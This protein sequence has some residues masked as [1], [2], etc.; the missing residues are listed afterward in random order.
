MNLLALWVMRK[1]EYMDLSLFPLSNKHPLGGS[2]DRKAKKSVEPLLLDHLQLL[3]HLPVSLLGVP[4]LL[5]NPLFLKATPL[6]QCSF[7][8]LVFPLLFLTL[9]EHSW[10][11]LRFILIYC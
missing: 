1:R 9:L 2:A 7:P 3:V 10:C 6:L 8:L 5:E 11:I 4:A